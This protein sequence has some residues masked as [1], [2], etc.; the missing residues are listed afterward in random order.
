M[1]LTASL[2]LPLISPPSTVIGGREGWEAP[3]RLGEDEMPVGRDPVALLVLL[4]QQREPLHVERVQRVHLRPAGPRAP[5]HRDR[6]PHCGRNAERTE[7][8]VLTVVKGQLEGEV[9]VAATG[10]SGS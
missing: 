3:A 7:V 10:C 5:P 6:G 1:L 4:E 9:G 8:M 2:F